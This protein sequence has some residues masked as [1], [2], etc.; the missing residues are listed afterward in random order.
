MA[1]QVANPENCK[2]IVILRNPVERT[3]AHW[4]WDSALLKNIKTDPLWKEFPD[5]DGAMDIEL[6][7]I[8]Q[9]AGGIT[10]SAGAGGAGYIQHSI[11]L[12]FLK[13]LNQFYPKE[14]TLI[15]KSEDF[16][17]NPTEIA[18]QAYEFLELPEY[19]PIRTEVKNEGPVK[20]VMSE[21]T[22]EKLNA[23]FKTRN[24]VLYEYIGRDMAW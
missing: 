15:L 17:K 20:E 24:E 8:S 5:F 14:N 7:Y 13:V 21:E 3:F 10:A 9:G 4:R 11:Y 1:S 16:F 6:D 18:K 19:Q 12:P 22:R 2:V 23:F